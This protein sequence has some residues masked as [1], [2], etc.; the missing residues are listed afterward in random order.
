VPSYQSSLLSRECIADHTLVVRVR[1]PPGL[2]FHAGQYVDLVLPRSPRHDV[3]DNLRT[4]SIASAPYEPDLEFLMRVSSTAFKQALNTAAIGVPVELKGPH[5]ESL[6]ACRHQPARNLPC[7][8]SRVAPFIS[9]LWQ[10]GRDGARH[11][12]H[13]FYTNREAGY[14]AYFQELHGL[15]SLGH[16]RLDFIPTVTGN[17]PAAW[18]DKGR[19]IDP[20]ILR[21]PV[22]Q[23]TRPF[24]TLPVLR[25]L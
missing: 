16:L 9:V 12:F 17:P 7:R 8:R 25:G 6:L 13:L 3:W 23:N 19:R 24:S 11:D 10:A 4:F 18:K 14:I 22:R 1:R 2:T 21:R 15:A 20:A 5:W